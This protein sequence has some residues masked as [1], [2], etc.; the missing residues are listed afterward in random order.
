MSTLL[1]QFRAKKKEISTLQEKK[2]RA[3]G[4]LEQEMSKLKEKYG[5]NSVEEANKKI[6]ELAMK[7]DEEESKHLSEI[8]ELDDIIAKAK[9]W[10]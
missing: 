3:E 10:N 4:R 1:D 7:L 6:E 9:K 5:V 2:S 8:K